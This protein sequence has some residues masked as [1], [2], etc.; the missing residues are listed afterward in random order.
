MT[1]ITDFVEI[2]KQKKK[3]EM[4]RDNRVYLNFHSF[5]VLPY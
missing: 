4:L 3:M 2:I 5:F 1:Y